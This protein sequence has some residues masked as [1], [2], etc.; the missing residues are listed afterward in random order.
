MLCTGVGTNFWVYL[1]PLFC[2]L[3]MAS[4][5]CHAVL[6]KASYTNSAPNIA[7]DLRHTT[8]YC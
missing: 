4:R 3:T 8:S 7:Q 1:T 5:T 2:C 6:D